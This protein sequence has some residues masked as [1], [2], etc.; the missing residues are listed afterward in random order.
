M[1]SIKKEPEVYEIYIME[2]SKI[3]EMHLLW[4]V[5]SFL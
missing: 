1:D 2:K 3:M 5:L 4:D